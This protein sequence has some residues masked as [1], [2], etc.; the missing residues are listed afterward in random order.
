MPKYESEQNISF[1]SIPESGLKAMS[2]E[3]ESQC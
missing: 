2:V 1:L 3:E